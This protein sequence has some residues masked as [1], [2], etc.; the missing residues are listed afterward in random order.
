MPLFLP[1]RRLLTCAVFC[2]CGAL[3]F[4]AADR[5]RLAILTD[6]GGDPDD[7][8]A[9]VRFLHYANEFEVELLIATA[10][11]TRHLA[12][13]QSARFAPE[14]WGQWRSPQEL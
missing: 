1:L 5:P 7:Q 9:L 4:A 6:I 3:T 12:G 8:Q 11:R 13:G 2:L 14:H 10:V